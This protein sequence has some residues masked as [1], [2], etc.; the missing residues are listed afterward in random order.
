MRASSA[1]VIVVVGPARLWEGA[2][3][4][5]DGLGA[6][7]LGGLLLAGILALYARLDSVLA[8]LPLIHAAP[9]LHDESRPHAHALT[10][11]VRFDGDRVAKTYAPGFL[12]RALYWFAFQAPFPYIRNEAALHSAMH[13]R[14]LA[15][16]LTE[17]WYGA[18]RVARVTGIERVDGQFGLVSDRVDGRAPTDRYVARAFLAGLRARSAPLGT[19]GLCA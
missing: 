9:V 12:P 5:T 13:R 1:A 4:P 2:H 17:Y 15:A 16:Q 6:Y 11:L 14:N 3:W 8:G 19:D 18:P 7:T 10:S